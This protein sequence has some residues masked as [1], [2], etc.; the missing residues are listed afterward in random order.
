MARPYA[1]LR[2]P[3]LADAVAT[4]AGWLDAVAECGRATRTGGPIA[5]LPPEA[6]EAAEAR[7]AVAEAGH[8]AARVG[9]PTGPRADLAAGSARLPPPGRWTWPVDDH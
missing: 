2:A 8:G 7:S 9:R 6:R 3:Q 1:R 5:A 4:L